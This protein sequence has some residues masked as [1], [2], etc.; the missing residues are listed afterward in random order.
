VE[1]KINNDT[2]CALSTP[3]GVGAIAVIRVSG[4][5]A[6]NIAQ[7]VCPAIDIHKHPSHSAHF[8]KVVK[9]NKIID[10]VVLIIF[11]GPRSYTGEDTVEISCHGSL[12][13]QQEIM[14]LLVEKGAR[15]ANKGEFTLR[16]FLN[17][18]LD[19]SQ[20]EAVADLISSDTEAAHK[21]AMRQMRG[22]FS[23]EIKKLREQ[24]VDF[25]ALV[26]LELDFS[27]EDVE[28]ANRKD[29]KKLVM[30]INDATSRL[31]NSFKVGN[32]IKNGVPV[33]IAGKPNVGKSTLLNTL[34]NEERA[35]VSEIAGT[36]RDTIED[37][38]HLGG[39]LFRFID[40]AGIRH[41]ID[42][43]E[44]IGVKKTLD[45]IKTSAIV[46]YVFDVHEISSGELKKNLMDLNEELKNSDSKII[47]VGNKIDR[48]NF[49]YTEKEFSSFSNIVF[50]SAREKQNIDKL[51]SKLVELV[52]VGNVTGG[53][54]II[55]NT[56]HIEALTKTS[57]ALERIIDA[58]D[59][60]ITTELLASE[61]KTAN[62]HLGTITGE[63]TNDEILDSIFS[64][65]CIGK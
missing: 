41:T 12:F 42:A 13:I 48:E 24:L 60:N 39:Y 56:R 2:I 37:E 32:V 53:E 33:V 35:I 52:S 45:K 40:T 54:T 21:I 46:I 5:N 44:A 50:I 19:L 4:A 22:G 38:I 30:K 25:A 61:I 8:A 26:E 49:S 20:A 27:E 43:I 1:N 15:P 31:I 34:L 59:K 47:P 16:A 7:V 36:T 29:L 51:T 63:V 57:D 65:F 10:D 62:Y 11:K 58:I 6:L 18:K 3:Q 9:N 28:F 17:G 23:E 14:N 55:T 64:R